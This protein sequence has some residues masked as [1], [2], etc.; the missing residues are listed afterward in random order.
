MSRCHHRVSAELLGHATASA[1]LVHPR[2]ENGEEAIMVRLVGE[3]W[4]RLS[5]SI[6]GREQA[7]ISVIAYKN[8]S[9][10]F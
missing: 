3:G 5:A 8:E 2:H 9:W 1:E 4:S 6:N 10:N 7:G